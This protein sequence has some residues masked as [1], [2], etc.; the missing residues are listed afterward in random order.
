MRNFQND[1]YIFRNEQVSPKI[2]IISKNIKF[3]GVLNEKV[4]EKEF[5]GIQGIESHKK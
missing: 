3:E 2:A 4:R 1:F 5:I